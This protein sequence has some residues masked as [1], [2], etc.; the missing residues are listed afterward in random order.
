MKVLL[1]HNPVQA[2]RGR[3]RRSSTAEAAILRETVQVATHVSTT[4]TCSP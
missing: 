4:R 2:P 1:A 3:R